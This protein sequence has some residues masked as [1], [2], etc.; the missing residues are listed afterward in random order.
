[1]PRQPDSLLCWV[2]HTLPHAPLQV[3]SLGLFSF[4]REDSS[5]RLP[6]RDNNPFIP[7]SRVLLVQSLQ[8]ESYQSSSRVGE[9]Q[10]GYFP[11]SYEN[12]QS[13]LLPRCF[14]FM[15]PSRVLWYGCSC[16]RVSLLP[17]SVVAFSFC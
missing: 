8:K 17:A 13:I 4:A 5:R 2:T 9:K 14:F 1:M 15:S 3:F 11:T 12:F 16:S 10:S 6:D 7:K